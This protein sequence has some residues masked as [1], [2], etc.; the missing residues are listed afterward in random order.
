M[1]VL[2]VD[3]VEKV[4]GAGQQQVAALRGVRPEVA[5]GDFVSLGSRRGA[6][7]RPYF[8]LSGGWT[9]RR[10]AG[11]GNVWLDTLSDAALAR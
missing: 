10:A 7:N 4:Y 6:G 3:R 2:M 8:T 1:S 9:T 11:C 5:A